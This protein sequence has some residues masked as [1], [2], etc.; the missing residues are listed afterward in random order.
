[1]GGNH[2]LKKNKNISRPKILPDKSTDVKGR[3][4]HVTSIHQLESKSFVIEW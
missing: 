1:M 3:N 2:H 4:S